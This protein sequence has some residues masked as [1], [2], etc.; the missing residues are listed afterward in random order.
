MS[1]YRNNIQK[2]RHLLRLRPRR[3]CG[4]VPLASPGGH[5]IT[6]RDAV[7]GIITLSLYNGYKHMYC[8]KKFF[9]SWKYCTYTRIKKRGKSKKRRLTSSPVTARETRSRWNFS[10]FFPPGKWGLL[11][12][13]TV[14]LTGARSNC[15]FKLKASN[16]LFTFFRRWNNILLQ[17]QNVA[18]W[19]DIMT[20]K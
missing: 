8:L 11:R 18:V 19:Q 4:S 14:M 1:L 12:S 3:R 2:A 13:W 16:F 7:R 17:L 20:L 10:L 5:V 15:V 6:A 9:F